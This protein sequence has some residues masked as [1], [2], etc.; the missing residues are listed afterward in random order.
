MALDLTPETRATG[1]WEK[2]LRPYRAAPAGETPAQRVGRLAA[3]LR[4]ARVFHGGMD[5]M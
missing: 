2:P 4:E 3:Q 1:T 5:Q